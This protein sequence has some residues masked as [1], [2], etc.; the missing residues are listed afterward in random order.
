M[1]VVGL[2]GSIGTGKSTVAGMFR[3]LGAYTVDWDELARNAVRPR[4]EAWEEIVEC[5]GEEFLNED[6]TLNRQK[7]AGAVFNNDEMR[8]RLNRI[9]HPQVVKEDQ[10]ITEEIRGRDADAIIVKDIP[11]LHESD[12]NIVVDKT[13]VVRASEQARLRRLQERGMNPADAR[14][15]MRSQ[16]PLDE[17]VKAADFVIDNDGS[18]EETRRQVERIYSSL[19]GLVHR[20][21]A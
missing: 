9:V 6:L 10:R 18:L 1:L 13:V 21:Q 20:G 19:R 14:M 7:L 5:F 15:R 17:K 8:G 12:L 11:L 3:E 16:L 4:S 2:T